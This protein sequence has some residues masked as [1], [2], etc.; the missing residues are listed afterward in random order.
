MI[1]LGDATRFTDPFIVPGRERP[2][3]G[4]Y[5]E[6]SAAYTLAIEPLYEFKHS[7]RLA[8]DLVI[9]VAIIL[10][11]A[12]MR[13]RHLKEGEKF[14]WH[15]WQSRFVYGTVAV[16]LVA[17]VL[18]VRGFGIMWLDFF[19]VVFAL[20]LHPSVEGWVDRFWKGRKGDGLN[21]PRAKLS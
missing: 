15:K 9:S 3:G 14:H 10:G 4:V 5:L 1:I 17:G 20:L 18:L 7:V 12:W 8:L 21:Q 16:V 6:A 19:L 13:Y 2:I 11:V